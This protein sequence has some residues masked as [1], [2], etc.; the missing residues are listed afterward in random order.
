MAFYR[1]EVTAGNSYLRASVITMESGS[2]KVTFTEQK[3]LNLGDQVI[4]SKHYRKN[5][6]TNQ[7]LTLSKKMTE[8]NA[9]TS[10]NIIDP[11]NISNVVG[12][13]TYGDVYAAM[14][15]LYLH[16]AAESDAA[17]IS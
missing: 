1:E 14:Y 9:N 17:N 16:V 11:A 6:V 12:T 10:F 13:M 15:S 3:V 4:V 7:T 8:Q 2:K 5:L